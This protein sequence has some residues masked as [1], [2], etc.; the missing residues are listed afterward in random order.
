MVMF[1][2][3]MACAQM[4]KQIRRMEAEAK[5]RGYQDGY[6]EGAVKAERENRK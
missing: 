6:K 1:G 5:E 4:E 2:V 3:I